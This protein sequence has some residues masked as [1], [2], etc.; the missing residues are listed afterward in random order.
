MKEL[1]K[2]QS[3][4][5]TLGDANRIRIV[6]FIAGRECSVSEV[7]QETNLSQPLVSHHLRVLRESGIL[8]TERKGPF[9]YYRLKDERLLTALQLLDE[10][11]DDI[12]IPEP[13]MDC[14]MPRRRRGR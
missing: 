1:Y 12:T 7:I 13:E 6:R 3:I 8:I 2:L 9:V 4:F 11:S 5:Q 14:F 10:I